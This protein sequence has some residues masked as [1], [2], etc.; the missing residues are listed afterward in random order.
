EPWDSEHNKKLIAKMPRIYQGSNKKLNAEGKTS[1][2][3]PVGK[4]TIWSPTWEQMRIP[5]S[6][7]D[8]TS[9][10]I[11]FVLG[12]DDSAVIWT[13]PDDLNFDPAKPHKGLVRGPQEPIL[14]AMGDGSARAFRQT[15]APETLG[16]LFARDNGK[17]KKLARMTKSGCQPIA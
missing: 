9:N 7:P 11:I 3:A 10:T 1:F 14:A 13:K 12:N 17:S 5:A 16:L 2:L 6:F 8:G 15:I 4:E